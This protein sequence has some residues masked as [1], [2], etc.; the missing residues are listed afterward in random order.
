MPDPTVVCGYEGLRPD[1][2]DAVGKGRG[3]ISPRAFLEYVQQLAPGRYI[4]DWCISRQL[5]WGSIPPGTA[6]G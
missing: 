3:E 4:R 6:R 2:L 1:G 5:W